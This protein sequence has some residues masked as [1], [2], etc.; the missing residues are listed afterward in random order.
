MQI[1]G[2][3][4]VEVTLQVFLFHFHVKL[5]IYPPKS[6]DESV[7]VPLKGG[8]HMSNFKHLTREERNIIEQRC[9]SCIP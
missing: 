3:E 5:E 4:K 8:T 1:S 9:R 6:Y 7:V 2:S